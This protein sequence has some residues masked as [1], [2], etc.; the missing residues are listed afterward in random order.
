[1]ANDYTKPQIW[2]TIWSR[3]YT[4]YE[5]HH[6]VFWKK[7][8]ERV[9]GRV[10]DL[11]CGS[12]SCWKISHPESIIDLC[13][14]DFS[15]SGIEEAKKN[16]PWGYFRICDIVN[17]GASSEIYDYTVLSGII[18]YYHDLKPILDEAFRI[19][20]KGGEVII[21]INVIDDF[22]DR[23]WNSDRIIKE[24]SLYGHP[25]LW[26]EDKIGWFVAISKK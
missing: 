13:G 23:H 24:F 25:T 8:R 6:Q 18:N 5:K 14:F 19:T 3:F 9:S 22:P 2:D 7:I 1:M 21:T 17:T 11:G 4:N 10:A 12:A 26:F 15:F 20:K 16:C